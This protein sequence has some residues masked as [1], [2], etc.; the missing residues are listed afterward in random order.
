MLLTEYD[1]DIVFGHA[2][3]LLVLNRGELIAERSPESV[4]ARKDVRAI[5]LCAGTL[6]EAAR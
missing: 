4:W 2:D 6:E 1:M 5:Y 3:R